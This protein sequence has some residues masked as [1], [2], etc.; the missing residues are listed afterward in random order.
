M[1]DEWIISVLRDVREFARLNAMDELAA[2]ID[3]TVDVAK[4]SIRRPGV[5]ARSAA[6]VGSDQLQPRNGF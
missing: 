5:P 6:D 1:A 3:Q 4:R 2:Q